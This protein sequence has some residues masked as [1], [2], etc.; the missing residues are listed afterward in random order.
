MPSGTSEITTV[1]AIRRSRSASAPGGGAARSA[2]SRRRCAGTPRRA[3]AQRAEPAAR[4]RR[5]GRSATAAPASARSRRRSRAPRRP[6][7]RRRSARRTDDGGEAVDGGPAARLDVGHQRE[8]A[9]QRPAPAG[10][11]R[12]RSGRPGA[13]RGRPAGQQAP[14][15]R[16][17]G[18][19][20]AASSRPKRRSA[21]SSPV[22][23]EQ[24]GLVEQRDRPG[25]G[26]AG[27]GADAASGAARRATAAPVP[28][29]SVRP[30]AEPVQLGERVAAQ[31]GQPA[32]AAVG[33][34]RVDG[35]VADAAADRGDQP[36]VGQPG[37]AEGR[38]SAP[39]ASG[40]A[41]RRRRR[42]AARRR[43]C[44]RSCPGRA[45]RRRP[46]SR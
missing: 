30:S 12:P 37:P 22:M 31:G 38:P 44:R 41:T 19:S 35:L 28:A 42:S 18:S 27:G 26:A 8:L 11:A 4:R 32:R 20:S 1:G 5:R 45:G 10:R 24:S 2:R 23:P 40:A 14:V 46:R 16:L 33:G 15:E 17:P 39:R 7:S 29:A 6:T 3:R 36:G 43:R 21:P 25:R 34:E 13:A 9:G